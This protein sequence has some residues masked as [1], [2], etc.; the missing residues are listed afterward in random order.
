MQKLRDTK[1]RDAAGLKEGTGPGDYKKSRMDV[2]PVFLWAFSSLFLSAW[3]VFPYPYFSRDS[4]Q[5]HM[6]LYVSGS[7]FSLSQLK[8]W[9]ICRHINSGWEN[10]WSSAKPLPKQ[11]G[12]QE[13]S[14][15]GQKRACYPRTQES[16]VST[17]PAISQETQLE[18]LTFSLTFF[19]LVTLKKMK[20]NCLW[21]KQN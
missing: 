20:W 16:R 1:G 17:L 18:A 4:H 15:S 10:G 2:L 21:E 14:G 6:S 9:L 3:T 13:G 7:S 19:F 11:C 12:L 5:E 8:L